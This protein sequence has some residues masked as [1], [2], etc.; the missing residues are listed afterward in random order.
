[1]RGKRVILS[2]L[3][4]LLL[5]ISAGTC[6]LAAGDGAA[7]KQGWHTTAKGKKYYIKP[8]GKRAVGWAKIGKKHYYF[9]KNGVLYAKTG[10]VKI[11]KYK[12]Y[13]K[14]DS[15]RLEA[16]LH[17]IGKKT[18]YFNSAGRLVTN[19][20]AGT[21]N[22]KY[23]NIDS[24][25]VVTRISNLEAQCEK[26]AAKFISRHTNASMTNAQKFRACFQ[27]L[28]AY[29]HYIPQA[30][31]WSEFNRKEWYYQKAIDIFRSFDLRGN[32]Y[33]FACAVAACAK[34]LGYKPKVVVITADHGF[35]MIDGKYY[36]NMRGGLFG[37]SV[38]S[39]PGYKIYTQADF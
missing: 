11:G 12:Y 27:Y 14:K 26:E 32:C 20:R 33:S 36:D 13:L 8:N 29:M 37:S 3:L 19:K 17:K 2:V 30:P 7:Q 4:L 39:H 15:S 16:G 21:L 38:P 35:V 18:Y 6:S 10:W 1:M 31:N 9:K 28:L 22:G 5:C 34:E 23:Y 25:G 24:K